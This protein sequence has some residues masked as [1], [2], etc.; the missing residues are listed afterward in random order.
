LSDILI[1]M[2][3]IDITMIVISLL[4]FLDVNREEV[5][6]YSIWKD[7]PEASYGFAELDFIETHL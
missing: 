6:T 7:R 3:M 4:Y 1:Q 2:M 5:E